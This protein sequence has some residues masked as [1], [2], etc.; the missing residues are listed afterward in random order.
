MKRFLVSAVGAL[1]FCGLAHAQLA[2]PGAVAPEPGDAAA[3]AAS[4]KKTHKPP[5]P[6]RAPGPEAVAGRDL[7]LNGADGELRVSGG[8]KDKSLQVD[9]FTLMGEVIS[10]PTQKCRIDI[11]ADAPIEAKAMGT[12]DG[13]PRYS[14]D[15]PACPLTFDVLDGAVLAPAQT[16]ACVFQAADCQASPGG[17]WGPEDAS[18]EKDAKA[19]AKERA[20]ADASISD[21]LKRLQARDKGASAATLSREQNDF[22]AQRA[23]T[24]RS[25]AGEAQH[26]FCAARLTQ[27]RAALLHMR[28]EPS[29]GATNDANN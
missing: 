13:L 21:S 17:L 12:P 24:C 22:A 5:P 10:D 11:V 28:A 3:K 19:I 2:L 9:K 18:L 25:Y 23:D 20:H 14:V 8:G 29:K 4:P 16:T 6:A 1:L 15:I 26:G 7:L 27:A